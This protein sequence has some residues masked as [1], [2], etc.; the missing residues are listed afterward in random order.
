[1]KTL[2]V[3]AMLM[4]A[5][6][7]LAQE[8]SPAPSGKFSGYM[9]GDYYYNLK[10][11]ANLGSQSDVATPGSTAMQ[12][13]QFRRIYFTYDDD[14][15]Q[16]FTSRFRLEADQS[17][18]TSNGKIGVFVKDAYLKWK[19]IFSG[20][21]LIFGIQPP[22]AYEVSEAVW[23]H[24]SLE[25]TIM[26]LR[27]IYASRDVG[28]SLKG[29]LVPGGSVN[30][31]IMIGKNSCNSPATTKYNRYSAHLEIE[32][33]VKILA[34]FYADYNDRAKRND[35]FNPGSTVTNGTMT[36]S[37]F[38][39]YVDPNKLNVGIEAF[40]SSTSNGYIVPGARSLSSLTAMGISVFGSVNLA[41][42]LAV[43]GRYDYFD[44]NTDSNA[45]GNSR[46]YIIGG[47]SWKPNKNVSIIPNIQYETYET[48]AGGN[49]IDPS[50]TARITLYYVFL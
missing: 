10:R 42:D 40:S 38:V 5:A 50:V 43:V 47:V 9:F 34:T 20:S 49:A 28:V 48:P 8:K 27:G 31:W 6:T 1:M 24:R 12:A 13:F 37:V 26:D 14:I 17:A 33:A 39:G 44:P 2:H 30:Y 23:G 41:S 18:N 45:K 35:P 22:P 11:D 3:L 36:A 29:R 15:S 25:K 7:L 46:N 19:N 32:P 21:D 4:F 16:Q